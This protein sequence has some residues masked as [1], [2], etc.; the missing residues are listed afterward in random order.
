MGSPPCPSCPRLVSA[1]V[2]GVGGSEHG[3]PSLVLRELP[4]PEGAPGPRGRRGCKEQELGGRADSPSLLVPR[5]CTPGPTELGGG[6][7][8]PSRRSGPES[9]VFFLKYSKT[10][11]CPGQSHLCHLCRG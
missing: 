5:P 7:H 11:P 1:P 3:V 8:V 10:P 4:Y 2:L 6:I 9:L